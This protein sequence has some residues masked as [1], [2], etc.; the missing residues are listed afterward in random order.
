MK[1]ICKKKFLNKLIIIIYFLLFPITS[2]AEVLEEKWTKSC[3]DEKKEICMIAI[4]KQLPI[5]GSDKR[6]TLATVIIQLGS[7]T[8][9]KMSLVDEKEK[10]YKLKEENKVV[11]ILTISFPLNVNLQKKPLVQVDKKNG[12]NVPYLYCNA[13]DGCITKV[14][15]AEVILDRFKSGKILT[16]TMQGYGNDK[17]MSINVSLKGFSKAY[18]SLLK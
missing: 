14:G 5:P 11:P 15:L 6:Q 9:K 10:T 16:L 2:S 17:G 8:E 12:F 1:K 18:A 4:K 13:N 7:S 3:E